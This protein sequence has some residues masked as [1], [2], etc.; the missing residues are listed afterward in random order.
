MITQEK[1]YDH[2]MMKEPMLVLDLGMGTVQK[3]PLRWR[4]VTI[5]T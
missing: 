5:R 1:C 3:T 4:L 2:L